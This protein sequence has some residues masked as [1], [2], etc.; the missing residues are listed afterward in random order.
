MIVSDDPRYWEPIANHPRV[1]QKLS[2]RGLE[3]LDIA[4]HW[5]SCLGLQFPGGGFIARRYPLGVWSVH[6]LFVPGNWQVRRC[7]SE[8]LRYLFHET[9]CVEVV[10]KIPADLPKPLRLAHDMKCTHRFTIPSCYPRDTGDVDM[11]ILSLHKADW[12]D[13]P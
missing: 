2:I 3:W 9:D 12:E 4:A 10:V 6:A 1:F 11:H 5:E 7:A 13:S 8:V